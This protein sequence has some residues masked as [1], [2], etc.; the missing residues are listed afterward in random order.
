M[1]LNVGPFRSPSTKVVTC[2]EERKTYASVERA[3]RNAYVERV[4]EIV[5]ETKQ[6]E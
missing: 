3:H 2:I 6:D 4:V 1:I 5:R